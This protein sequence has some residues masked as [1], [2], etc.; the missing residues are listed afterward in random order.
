[1]KLSKRDHFLLQD[2]YVPKV[3]QYL[4]NIIN[5]IVTR[6]SR[7]SKIKVLKH[8]CIKLDLIFIL[9]HFL[10]SKESN[11]VDDLLSLQKIYNIW[12]NAQYMIETPTNLIHG[13]RK[14]GR[15]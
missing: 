9:F 11:T 10:A 8:Y 13:P 2:T 7:L 6:N 14:K 5:I 4:K 1:M 12:L 15:R 3:G